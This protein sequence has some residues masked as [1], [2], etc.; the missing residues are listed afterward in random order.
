MSRITIK[1]CKVQLNYINNVLRKHNIP[2]V[3]IRI[4]GINPQWK[5]LYVKDS[6]TR[7]GNSVATHRELYDS[8]VSYKNG[9]EIAIAYMQANM[10]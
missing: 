7:I 1:D 2:E 5:T 6:G 4:S 3:E 8:L 9:A 10:M